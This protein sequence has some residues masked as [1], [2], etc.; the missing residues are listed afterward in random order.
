MASALVL[1]LALATALLIRQPVERG[2]AGAPLTSRLGLAAQAALVA[3]G[4]SEGDFEAARAELLTILEA[5]SASLPDGAQETVAENLEIIG[6]QISAIS[7][8]LSQ[9]PNNPQLA[10][11]LAAA[12]R[13]E[14]DLL[15]RAAALPTVD[16]P[17]D[18]S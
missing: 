10:R 1:I 6:A 7:E 9:D 8:E 15:Q 13:R 12:Y 17:M 14:L 11:L 3:L 5:R 2:T 16:G 18:D 4:S